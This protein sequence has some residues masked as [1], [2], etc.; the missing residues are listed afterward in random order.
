MA[1]VESAPLAD[2]VEHLLLT[3]DNT[4]A[5]ILAHQVGLEVLDDPTFA[6]GAR[7]TC[8]Y[9]RSSASTP[10]ASC[11]TTAAGCRVA[12]GSAPSA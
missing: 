11:S 2:L 4:E 9:W 10:A 5:D 6:G 3:S 12:T 1:A 7:A 8:R